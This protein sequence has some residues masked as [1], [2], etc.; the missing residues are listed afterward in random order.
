MKAIVCTRYGPPEDL[1]YEEVPEPIAK[2]HEV[3]VRVHATAVNDYDWS[4]VR[5]TPRI[6]RLLFGLFRPKHP[7]PGMELSGTVVKCGPNAT[8]FTVG[9]AVYG[10]I[11]AKGFGSFA[12][13]V[14]IHESALVH[15]PADMSFVDAAATSH[16]SLLAYQA[17]VDIGKIQPGQRV[18][19]NGAGGGV[20][21]FAVQ[22]ALSYGATITGVDS[23]A[24]T[25]VLLEQGYHHAMDY[26]R[27]DFTRTG[28][29]YDLI[30]D[31]RITRSPADLVRALAPGGQ[32][33]AIGGDLPRMLQLLVAR[34]FG[35]RQLHMLA[36]RS[37]EGLEHIHALYSAGK[38]KPVIDGPYP[39]EEAAQQIRRFGEGK[40]VGKVV[41][42]PTVHH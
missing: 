23:A 4:W 21:L 9:D 8:R 31:C 38:L 25:S 15:K 18:L 16:A 22:I 41:L 24:K 29:R 33:V 20:G 3:L 13:Q 34:L 12:E 39:L 36:L 17:L 2:E 30:L 1:L 14:A 40:H 32:Y 37:N 28:E 5:G 10:D 26:A 27:T 35:K 11:S 42:V 6:Y 19:I 7:I